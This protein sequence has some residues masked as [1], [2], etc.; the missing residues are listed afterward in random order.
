MR[1]TLEI[2]DDVME[3]AK[4]LARLKKQ[5]IGQTISELA[6]RGLTPELTPIREMEFGVPVWKHKPGAIAVTSEMV[7]NLVE[8]E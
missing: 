2:A 4:S 5:G 7:R 8:E 6:R 1:T 3:A